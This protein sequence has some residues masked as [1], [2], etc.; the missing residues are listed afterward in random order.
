[1]IDGDSAQ[2]MQISNAQG[3]GSGIMF[4]ESGDIATNAHVRAAACHRRT[5]RRYPAMLVGTSPR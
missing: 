3:L 4:D 2:V 1:M 5:R